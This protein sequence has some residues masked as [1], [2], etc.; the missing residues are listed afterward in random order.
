VEI[1]RFGAWVEGGK[2]ER[3]GLRL[4]RDAFSNAATAGWSG[5]DRSAWDRDL[6]REFQRKEVREGRFE[7]KIWVAVARK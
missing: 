5:E 2:W 3:P 7:M 1:S 4:M 6:E